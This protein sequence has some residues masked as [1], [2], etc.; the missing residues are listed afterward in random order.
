M[1]KDLVKTKDYDTLEI[2]QNI[3][4]S[5]ESE[6]SNN[7]Y[8]EKLQGFYYECGLSADDVDGLSEKTQ[9]LFNVL[10][11]I[12]NQQ[13]KQIQDS[14]P[15]IS[16]STQDESKSNIVDLIE[17]EYKSVL[18]NSK[19][20]IKLFE[21]AEKTI[22]SGKSIFKI[23][24][25]YCNKSNFDQSIKIKCVNDP[26]LIYFDPNA[27]SI[28]KSDANYVC[29]RIDLTKDDFKRYYPDIELVNSNK[30]NGVKY[31][32]IDDNKNKVY[33][34]FKYY[35]YVYTT[36]TIYLMP[37]SSV[38]SEQVLNEQ[39]EKY[40][41]KREVSHKKVD[42][43]TIY[44]DEI[45]QQENTCFECL[46]YFQWTAKQ[47]KSSNENKI[48]SFIENAIDAQRTKNIMA[49]EFFTALLKAK[50]AMF[51]I[52]ESQWDD[53][54]AEILRDPETDNI[55][56]YKDF[57]KVPGTNDYVRTPPPSI[58]PAQPVSSEYMSVFT[59]MDSS[60][61]TILGAYEM[62]LNEKEM[63]GVALYNMAQYTSGM[64]SPVMNN[65][66]DCLEHMTLCVASGIKNI[67]SYESQNGNDELSDFDIDS[68][69]ITVNPGVNHKLQ[70]EATVDRILKLAPESPTFAKW[71][72]QEG[73]PII[74]KNMDLNNKDALIENY[75]QFL[76]K[77]Q[78][79]SQQQPQQNPMIIEQQIKE[80]G[81][82]IKQEEADTKRLKVMGELHNQS[83]NS[84]VDLKDVTNKGSNAH[85]GNYIQLKKINAENLKTL[86]GER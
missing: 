55:L 56:Y 3:K 47:Y 54:T 69:D 4:K 74:L 66:Y 26:T 22:I 51:A 71:L 50:K 46:P 5:C 43:L 70:Q 58:V 48:K 68:L 65:L 57:V 60:I 81:L 15:E 27:E 78:Q 73:I 52:G 20:A 12:V 2:V 28:S 10:E 42:C 37:D 39:S 61:Q 75:E 80:K 84:A 45:I 23:E 76:S 63:S 17:K 34:V 6:D 31:V 25:D 14:S 16:M 7:K 29:E 32:S 38:V 53:L 24:A 44:N 30:S 62:S 82:S 67:L 72:D 64:L 83:F 40:T 11:P 85:V 1:A 21:N 77:E 59:A 19:Y 35:C 41:S 18:D 13:L 79:A 49:N 9:L 86:S 33:S 36:E 8:Y